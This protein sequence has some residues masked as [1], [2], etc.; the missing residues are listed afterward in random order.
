MKHRHCDL[1]IVGGGITGAWCLHLAARRFPDWSIVLL[2]RSKIA[3]GATAHS[4][5]VF[6]PVGR[7]ARERHLAERSAAHYG[8]ALEQ[9]PL[10]TS[11]ASAYWIAESATQCALRE[12][13][14]GFA[15]ERCQDAPEGD[16][17]LAGLRVVR[18]ADEILLCGGVPISMEPAAVA[19]ALIRRA[20]LSSA[21]ATACEGVAVE[22]IA[23]SDAVELTLSDGARLTADRVIVAVGP[24][25]ARGEHRD[26]AAGAN[27]RVKKVVAL[28]I[29]QPP[30]PRAPAVI[31]PGHDAYLVPI[32]RRKQ[33]LFSICSEQWDVEVDGPRLSIDAADCDLARSLLKRY[34]PDL[35]D[36]CIGGRAFC[37]AYSPDGEPVVVSRDDA[38][39]I[40]VG[41]GSGAGFR[42]APGV[43]EEAVLR[44]V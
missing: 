6:F 31:L 4:A 21:T 25:I 8:E 13:G 35:A 32:P 41:G 18:G 12:L 27:L 24:W 19:T 38:R 29:D 15:V 42:L 14:V 5:G 22:G 36:H 1:A 26:W 44:L 20:V 7:S 37:D 11:A 17:K 10:E 33:W 16:G 2:E 23:A 9:L 3:S 28:H 43:A 30:S 39:V 40:V 34:F